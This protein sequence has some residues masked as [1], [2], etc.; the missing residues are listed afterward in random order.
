M[1]LFM[2]VCYVRLI[3]ATASLSGQ[4]VQAGDEQL[5]QA[6]RR[7]LPVHR[8]HAR[9]HALPRLSPSPRA[10]SRSPL[11]GQCARRPRRRRRYRGGQAAAGVAHAAQRGHARRQELHVGCAARLSTHRRARGRAGQMV[12]VVGVRVRLLVTNRRRSSPHIQ[13][14]SRL[15]ISTPA[16]SQ[17][18]VARQLEHASF[19]SSRS[20]FVP[21]YTVVPGIEDHSP[22]CEK[23]TRPW[24]CSVIRPDFRIF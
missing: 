1:K 14:R 21:I 23:P 8:V 4:L 22:M 9:A 13:H 10:A 3:D 6:S 7:H 19:V 17:Q 15:A 16:R 24:S 18:V 5:V 12:V 20:L 2:C 11:C